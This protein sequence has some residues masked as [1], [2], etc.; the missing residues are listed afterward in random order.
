MNE[1]DFS[2]INT[3]LQNADSITDAQCARTES[4]NFNI[5]AAL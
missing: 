3:L 5:V 4:L 2:W 1:I